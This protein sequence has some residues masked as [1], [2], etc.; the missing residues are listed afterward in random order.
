MQLHVKLASTPV[1]LTMQV[2]GGPFSYFPNW[3]TG[4]NG[5]SFLGFFDQRATRAEA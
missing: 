4:K 5:P 2:R 1:T 3:H